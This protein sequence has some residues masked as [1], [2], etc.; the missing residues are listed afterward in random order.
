MWLK[1]GSSTNGLWDCEEYDVAD[2][3]INASLRDVQEA[4]GYWLLTTQ[5]CSRR[6]KYIAIS[7]DGK[8]GDHRGRPS[9]I[10]YCEI[11]AVQLLAACAWDLTHDYLFEVQAVAGVQVLQQLNGLQI[12]GHIFAAYVE[13]VALQMEYI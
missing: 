5:R 13:L 1:R 3:F 4:M 9:S 12:G 7:K 10:H 2:C 6:Q 8:A 11:T